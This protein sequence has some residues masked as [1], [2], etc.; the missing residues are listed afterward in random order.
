[1]RLEY[2]KNKIAKPAVIEQEFIY[3]VGIS[4]RN[5]NIELAL[6]K[7]IIVQVNSKI[8]EVNGHK[9]NGKRNLYDMSD[10]DYQFIE[11][12]LSTIE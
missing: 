3:G 10:E 4:N 1:M 8:Y 6:E 5:G 11:D 7:G 12:N 2:E 9:Y